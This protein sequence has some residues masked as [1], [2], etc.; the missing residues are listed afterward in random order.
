MNIVI[1]CFG[2]LLSCLPAIA[3]AQNHGQT[4]DWCFYLAKNSTSAHGLP[5]G[6]LYALLE[7]KQVKEM[8]ALLANCPPLSGDTE[9]RE[10]WL[11]SCFAVEE[12]YEQAIK[13]FDKISAWETIPPLVAVKAAKSYLEEQ[14]NEKAIKIASGVICKW[15]V[16]EAYQVRVACYVLRGQ[17]NLAIADFVTLA[18]L[19]KIYERGYLVKAANILIRT[20]Q[21][22]QALA[23]LERATR[24]KGGANA[25]AIWLARA[26]CYKAKK[27]WQS[28]VDSYSKAITLALPKPDSR[29]NQN[30]LPVSYRDRAVCYEK[31][32]MTRQAK[33][34]RESLSELG[35]SLESDLMGGR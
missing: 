3:Q 13:L 11:A 1:A 10:M 4:N 15:P 26:D 16:S 30:V 21:N 27:Q 32:G 19:N 17:N 5:Q 23:L 29:D 31:L 18:G 25:S 2:G 35:R 34:D 22:E 6:K 24:A 9:E 12:R 28:A 14:Q 7:Q 8:R 20:G 33:S